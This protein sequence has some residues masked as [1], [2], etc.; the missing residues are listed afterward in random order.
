[1]ILEEVAQEEA[2]EEEEEE[3]AL[4]DLGCCRWER[5]GQ[6]VIVFSQQVPGGQIINSA[7]H[8]ALRKPTTGET[9][10]V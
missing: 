8:K 10:C 1:M 9:R 3:G 2:E 6:K 7:A 4:G 5:G